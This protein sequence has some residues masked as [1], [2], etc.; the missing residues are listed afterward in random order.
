[1]VPVLWQLDCRDWLDLPMEAYLEQPASI[2]RPGSILL[3]HDGFAGGGV[4]PKLDRGDLTRGI[5]DAVGRRNRVGRSI[6]D[7]L[8]QPLTSLRG[9]QW[10][11][12]P[13]LANLTGDR[14][15]QTIDQ[16]T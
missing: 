16:P 9:Q 10:L 11:D 1:M 4:A 5:L 15:R 12:L 2:S 13:R 14:S 8:A 7:A 6:R 3:A